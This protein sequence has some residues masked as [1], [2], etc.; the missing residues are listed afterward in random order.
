MKDI[1]VEGITMTRLEERFPPK[2]VIDPDTNISTQETHGMVKAGQI[3]LSILNEALPNIE[4]ELKTLKMW[5][6]SEFFLN[7]EFI[8]HGG[9]N[10]VK[11]GKNFLAFHGVNRFKMKSTGKSRYSVEVD[12]NDDAFVSL[13]NKVNEIS[14]KVDDEGNKVYDFDTHGVIDVSFVDQPDFT[15]ALNSKIEIMLTPEKH[16]TRT[17]GLWLA[18]AKNPGETKINLTDGSKIGAMEKKV[19]QYVIGENNVSVGP[20]SEMFAA[21]KDAII[22][23]DAAVIWHATKLLGVEINKNLQ[24]FD[25]ERI[26]V[27]EGIVIRDL[28][29]GKT[30]TVGDKR[31]KIPYPP[32]KITGEFIISGLLSA[33]R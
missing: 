32:F 8:E 12:Y 9:T 29:S 5:R 24:T 28:P 15:E 27:G 33:F 21:D 22:A 14:S 1:D 6:N 13:V 19:Y 30:R 23:I 18:G 20:L 31:V 16:E 26:P 25:N 2:I 11:Y 10:V 4:K 17:L 7:T 3:L